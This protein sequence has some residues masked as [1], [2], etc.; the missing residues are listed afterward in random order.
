MVLAALGFGGFGGSAGTG[1]AATFIST[2]IQTDDVTFGDITTTNTLVP[3]VFGGAGGAGG[4]GG[5]G[6]GGAGFGG[7]GGSG[8]SALQA[9]YS[10]VALKNAYLQ[11]GN[12]G[13]GG[14]G[15]GGAGFGGFGGAGAA[16]GAATEVALA[17]H[18]HRNTGFPRHDR[19][20]H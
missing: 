1:G 11:G 9:E 2:A 12:G 3:L 5:I 14:I 4:A 18:L 15:S 10:T 16:G 20:N 17:H 13:D 7:F 19:P 6:T 8:G